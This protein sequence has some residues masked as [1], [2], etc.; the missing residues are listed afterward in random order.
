MMGDRKSK[1]PELATAVGLSSESLNNS[2]YRHLNMKN[3]HH[4]GYW[5]CSQFVTNEIM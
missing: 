1:V 2:L 5:D 3:S 4:D